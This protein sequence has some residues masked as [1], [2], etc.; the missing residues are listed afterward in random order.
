MAEPTDKRKKPARRPRKDSA[1]EPLAVVGIGVCAASF[2]ALLSLFSGMH[3]GLDAA[4]VI[5]VRQQD[6]LAVDTVIEALAEQT[7]L[8]VRK[9]KNRERLQPGCIHV[10]GGD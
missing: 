3:D 6:G 8:P 10:G 4:Y 5:A 9:A 7:K 1:P 2:R